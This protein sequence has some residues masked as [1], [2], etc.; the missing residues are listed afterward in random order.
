MRQ[1]GLR[2]R[3]AKELVAPPHTAWNSAPRAG[4]LIKPDKMNQAVIGFI[5]APSGNKVNKLNIAVC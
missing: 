3:A 4:G 2:D 1:D 5:S